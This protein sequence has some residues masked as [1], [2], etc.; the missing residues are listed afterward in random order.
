[1]GVAVGAGITS[2]LIVV[3][4]TGEMA[5]MTLLAGSSMGWI[6]PTHDP[7]KGG[8][9]SKI[10]SSKRDGSRCSSWPHHSNFAEYFE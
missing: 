2:V 3:V 7:I 5:K 6:Q 4:T 10:T 9:G 8:S 1:M